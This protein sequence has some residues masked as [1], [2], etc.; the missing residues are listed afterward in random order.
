MTCT[1]P[2]CWDHVFS[3]LEGVKLVGKD[4]WYAKCPAHSDNRPSLTLRVGN[5]GH[6]LVRCQRNNSN[7]CTSAEVM[8]AIGCTLEDLYNDNKRF[9]GGGFKRGGIEGRHQENVYDYRDLDGTILFQVVRFR[10][11]D[12]K[13]EFRQRH[14]DANK[15]DWVWNIAGVRRVLYRWPELAACRAE[16]PGKPLFV[17]EGEKAADKMWSLNLAA[18]TNSGGAGKFSLTD[19]SWLAGADV[20]VLPDNDP[21]DEKYKTWV[22]Q[23]HAEEVCKLLSP[24]ASRVRYVDLPDLAE[25]EDAFDFID[26]R[27]RDGWKIECIVGDIMKRVNEEE[28]WALPDRPHPLAA[29]METGAVTPTWATSRE[30]TKLLMRLTDEF[31]DE[32]SD[33]E[34]AHDDTVMI[35]RAGRL[36][37]TIAAGMETYFGVKRRKRSRPVGPEKSA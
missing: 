36:I 2:A 31:H 34:D 26:K 18:T 6:L 22:G 21:Y 5:N 8:H 14:W 27:L 13:K 24:I 4:S 11:D 7:G 29:I 35:R 37:A 28:P 16:N 17:V 12:G 30:W 15:R 3:S 19:Y 10:W 20:V 25:K 33:A 32:I 9:T 1:W 23:D